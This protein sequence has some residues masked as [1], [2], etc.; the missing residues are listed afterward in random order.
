M[1]STLNYLSP[2]QF[3]QQAEAQHALAASPRWLNHNP[4]ITSQ[5]QQLRE[6]RSV[7]KVTERRALDPNPINPQGHIETNALESCICT[8]KAKSY[9]EPPW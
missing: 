6:T 8:A 3:E 7:G 2:A 1:H 4:D 9:T 5:N